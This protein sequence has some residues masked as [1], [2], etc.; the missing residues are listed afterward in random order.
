METE[1]L[2]AE[3]YCLIQHTQIAQNSWAMSKFQTQVTFSIHAITPVRS[4]FKIWSV[5]IRKQQNNG[6]HAAQ[7]FQPLLDFCRRGTELY[8]ATAGLLTKNLLFLDMFRKLFE[9]VLT[10]LKPTCLVSFFL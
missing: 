4:G 3:L 2:N 7:W 8:L 9:T 1:V 5:F 10:L 6:Y